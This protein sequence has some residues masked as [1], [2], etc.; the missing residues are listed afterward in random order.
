MSIGSA[1]VALAA[2]PRLLMMTDYDGTLSPLVADPRRAL[3]D[4]ATKSVL[5][6][7]AA[8]PDTVVAVVSGRR[9]S[10]LVAFLDVPELL[11]IGGHG[12]E[13][14]EPVELDDARRLALGRVVSELEGIAGLA[15]GAF[16]EVKETSAVLHVRQVKPDGERLRALALDGPAHIPGVRVMIGKELVELSVSEMDKGVAVTRLRARYPGGI[17]CFIGDDVTDEDA[18]AALQPPDFGVKVGQG[19]TSANLRLDGQEEV[20]PLL[21]AICRLR[22]ERISSVP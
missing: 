8:L 3:P 22:K 21:Q 19:E 1:V 4:V 14:G 11:L 7:L 12:A 17:A 2:A 16:V 13:T 18:F 9:L 10:D 6:E 20:T 15:E 5:G